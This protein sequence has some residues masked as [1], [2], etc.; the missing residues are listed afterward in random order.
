MAKGVVT[1]FGGSGFIGRY[2]VKR[3]A[4]QGWRIRV[5]VRHPG[6]A[7]F[8]KPMGEVG[9]ITP[10]RAKLQDQAAVAE[11]VAGAQAVINLV[12]ILYEKRQ[13]SFEDIHHRGAERIAKAAAAAGATALV[14]ISALGADPDSQAAYAR[15]KA[16][17]EAAVLAAFPTA[18]VIR[19][20]VVFGAE[21]GFL[22]L[23][24]GLARL[25]PVLPLMGGGKTKFQPVYV[26]DVADAVVTC[27]TD[28]KCRGK[29][30]E[31]G[32]P[33]VYSFEELMRYMLKE[34]RRRRFLVPW[35]FELA[36]FQAKFLE[37]LPVPPLTRDQVKLLQSDNVVSE[38][39]LT[40]ADLGL[41]PTALEVIAPTYLERYR[42]HG[43]FTQ[44]LAV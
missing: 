12:G 25:S 32:G 43:R 28:P 23:F 34:I 22:N 44:T 31:L 42:P 17:G 1:I 6:P 41:Q 26:G 5:A 20:S 15:S 11:A 29:T 7:R 37:M 13:C 19:P 14:Q 4:R 21:D 38:G 8:L 16:A 39:A 10:I 18:S 40:L 24:A 30:Y 9:Q 27:M 33:A 36:D 3:L 2:V 35:P